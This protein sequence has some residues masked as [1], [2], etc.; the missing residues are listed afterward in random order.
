M[1]AG[2]ALALTAVTRPFEPAV[3]E[4]VATPG[5]LL[6]QVAL[7]VTSLVVESVQV[8][9]AAR[10]LNTSPTASDRVAG[11]TAIETTAAGAAVMVAVPDW[12]PWAAVIVVEPDVPMAVTSPFVPAVS[13]T[14]ATAGVP[15][16]QVALAVTSPVVASV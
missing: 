16:V 12:P 8:A 11:V 4:T 13:E 10:E 6:V 7:P 15:L 1:V 5:A 2:V 14:V 3:L 9:V